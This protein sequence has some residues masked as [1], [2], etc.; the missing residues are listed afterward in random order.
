MTVKLFKLIHDLFKTLTL[1]GRSFIL[2]AVF[3]NIPTRNSL[4][5]FLIYTGCI[6]HRVP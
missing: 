6:C 4:F 1:N 5:F 2:L 3:A